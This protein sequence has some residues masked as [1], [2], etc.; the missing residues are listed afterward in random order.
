MEWKNADEAGL[1]GGRWVEG[2][3][4]RVLKAVCIKLLKTLGFS[5]LS[6]LK[7]WS[8]GG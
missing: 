5:G 8:A 6:T 2:M 1:F 4:L 3:I 7:G